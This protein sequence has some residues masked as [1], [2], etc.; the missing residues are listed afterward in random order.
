MR[1]TEDDEGGEE[2]SL[3]DTHGYKDDSWVPADIGIPLYLLKG[4]NLRFA[5]MVN[6]ADRPPPSVTFRSGMERWWLYLPR[7]LSHCSLCRTEIEKH[8]KRKT[9][10]LTDY[11]REHH[12]ELLDRKLDD[13]GYKPVRFFVPSYSIEELDD[14]EEDDESTEEE[15]MRSRGRRVHTIQ[16]IGHDDLADRARREEGCVS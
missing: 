10:L 2:E 6:Q 4:P 11:L 5:N 12:P 9:G 13:R 15:D 14:E 7:N 8:V 3:V 1:T 16:Y